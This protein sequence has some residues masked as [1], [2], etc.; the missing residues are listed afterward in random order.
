AATSTY[1]DR[2]KGKPQTPGA[3]RVKKEKGEGRRGTPRLRRH[4]RSAAGHD[5]EPKPR[6]P[7]HPRHRR[8]SRNAVHVLG[9]TTTSSTRSC[10]A[11]AEHQDAAIDVEPRA[12]V[13]ARA[14]PLESLSTRKETPPPSTKTNR[15]HQPAC[16]APSRHGLTSPRR[17][18]PD[19]HTPVGLPEDPD[20][21]DDV[22]YIEEEDK[23][24]I[25]VCEL[26]VWTRSSSSNML[27]GLCRC[28]QGCLWWRLKMKT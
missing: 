10:S 23:D 2:A 18:H 9:S 16:A 26:Q 4:R 20:Y 27:D 28:A 14:L 17:R 13:V 12:E 7:E 11:A 24:N 6:T 1:P 8:R 19:F 15:E 3:I 25:P 22:D 21:F 5:N